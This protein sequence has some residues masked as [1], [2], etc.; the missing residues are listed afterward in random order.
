M[1]DRLSFIGADMKEAANEAALKS[2]SAD[3]HFVA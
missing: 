3:G 2:T 1:K